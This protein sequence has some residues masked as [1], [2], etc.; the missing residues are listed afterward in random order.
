MIKYYRYILAFL[1]Y[2]NLVAAQSSA[3]VIKDTN[4][5]ERV[6]F[7]ITGLVICHQLE[8][9]NMTLSMKFDTR[10]ED[11]HAVKQFVMTFLQQY[12]KE[13]DFWEIMN[14]KL[15]HAIVQQFPEITYMKSSIHLAPDRTLSFPR[16]STVIYSKESSA[17]QEAFSFTKLDYKIS[18]ETFDKLDFHVSFKVKENP[19]PFDYPDYQWVDAAMEEFFKN[20][21]M[22]T[23]QWKELKPQLE[24]YLL[25]RFS[26]L[27]S[28]DVDV[29]S[30]H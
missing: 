27:T 3:S 26:T 12:D 18:N 13:M 19:D 6:S 30:A 20:R 11:V 7:K 2:F 8:W 10:L 22:S 15:A 17:L 16:Q 4:S 21:P 9:R 5:T 24:A 29:V 23:N 28:I 1:I 14:A 25:E